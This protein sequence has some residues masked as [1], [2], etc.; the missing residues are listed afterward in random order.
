MKAA[1][2]I[3]ITDAEVL[4]SVEGLTAGFA[5]YGYAVTPSA[6]GNGDYQRR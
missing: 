2:K 6:T 4:G 3:T 5:I 1:G